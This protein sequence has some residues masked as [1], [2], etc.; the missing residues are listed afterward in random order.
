MAEAVYTRGDDRF[1]LLAAA[2]LDGG[3]LIQLPTGEAA[4][5][6]DADPVSAAT[7]TD[8][9]R[10]RGKATVEAATGWQGVAGQDVYWD[11]SANKL[12]YLKVNDRDFF[13]GV[14]VR[15]KGAADI[16]AEVDLNKRQRFDIDLARDWFDTAPIGTQAVGGF[17]EPRVRGG[18]RKLV[19]SATSEAQK[20]DLFS[21]DRFA[22][23]AKW[24]AEF[25]FSLVDNGAG[26]APDLSIGVANA[27]NATDASAIT[28]RLFVHLD[29]NALDL[30]A[31]SA[32]GTTTVAL[33]DTTVNVTEGGA[34]ANRVHV[35]FDGRDPADVQVIV[36]GALVLGSTVFR[37]DAATGPLGLLIH[38]EKTSAADIYEVDIE[39]SRVWYSEQ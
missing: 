37:L 7:Y 10:S 21:R 17:G 24:C 35:L 11:H 4:F 3:Q 9:L 20:I 15:D 23:G 28:Q 22:V 39:R 14:L 13:A 5:L 12:T 6:D 33:T 29:G 18:G 38:L 1:Q 19:L 8:Q 34:V 2:T 32:D 30:F 26:A 16:T 36:N 27:T 25:V 31:E